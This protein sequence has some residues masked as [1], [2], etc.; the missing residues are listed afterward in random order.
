MRKKEGLLEII[1]IVIFAIF[2]LLIIC[3]ATSR[4]EKINNGEMTWVNQNQIDK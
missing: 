3:I 4:V 2:I 1:S